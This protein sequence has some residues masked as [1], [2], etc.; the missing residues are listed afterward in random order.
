MLHG[1]LQK[2]FYVKIVYPL[3]TEYCGQKSMK[4]GFTLIIC[5]LLCGKA[6]KRE[7]G[8]CPLLCGKA[9]KRAGGK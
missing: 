5:L 2:L 9:S 3:P 6:S 7:G 8:K 1:V 4:P